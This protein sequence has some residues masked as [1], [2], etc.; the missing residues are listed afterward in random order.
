M[1]ERRKKG[2]VSQER[3]G[4]QEREC[5]AIQSAKQRNIPGVSSSETTDRE[6]QQRNKEVNK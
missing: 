4:N 1:P 6:S 5:N 3:P 2:Q